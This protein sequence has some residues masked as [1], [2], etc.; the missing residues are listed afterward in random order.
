MD[1]IH[2]DL[3]VV[4]GTAPL[5]VPFFLAIGLKL[6]LVSPVTGITGYLQIG[7]FTVDSFA[8]FTLV[9]KQVLSMTSLSFM[10]LHQWFWT[11]GSP[12]HLHIALLGSFSVLSPQDIYIAMS[13]NLPAS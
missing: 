6:Y 4:S 12:V 10:S 1:Q 9:G 3:P 7:D 5:P 2:L 13:P 11:S 8:I